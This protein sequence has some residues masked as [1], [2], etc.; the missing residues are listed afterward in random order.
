[1]SRIAIAYASA[2][3][4]AL[5]RSLREQIE[6]LGETPSHVEL[7]N[8]LARAAGYRNFQHLKGEAEK[9][10]LPAEP[11]P[12]PADRTRVDRVANHFD[13]N[14][15]L[16][17]WP[18]KANHQ[19][20]CLWVMWSRLPARDVFDERR[21]SGWLNDWH[22][23]GDS[24]MLRRDMVGYRMVTRNVNGSEYRRVEQKPPPE[25]RLL[26]EKLGARTAAA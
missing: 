23:F 16:L 8:M 21:I 4:S 1:M 6:K 10:A 2:D 22:H 3:V 11:P 20:L 24:A 13:A 5:A 25:L 7:L 14:G 12:P 19:E 26:L 17:R 18:S 15:M 9:E